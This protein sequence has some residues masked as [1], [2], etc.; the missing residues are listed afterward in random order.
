MVGDHHRPDQSRV[1]R[2][3][4]GFRD[5]ASDQRASCVV[6]DRLGRPEQEH[7]YVDEGQVV[8]VERHRGSQDSQ[9][10]G[11]ERRRPRSP[12]AAGRHD[13]RWLLQR[14]RIGTRAHVG[15]RAPWRRR[16]ARR[17]ST[18]P[19]AGRRR[20][21]RRRPGSRS[22][23]RTRSK[24]NHARARPEARPWTDDAGSPLDAMAC[25]PKGFGA[26]VAK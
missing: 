3:E 24:G 10:P 11:D 1:G 6:G 9:D 26:R 20:A 16:T 13:R 22:S 14:A 17:L 23:I 15:R 4:S 8:D 7:G 5:D 21:T 12:R 2:P 19:A 18:R 25:P